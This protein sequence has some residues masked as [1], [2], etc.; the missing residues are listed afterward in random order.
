MDDARW[1]H[2]DEQGLDRLLPGDP[3]ALDPA[4]HFLEGDQEA[5]A[6]YVLSLDAVNFGSGWFHGLERRPGG[7]GY[8]VVARRLADRFRGEGGWAPED[9]SG[10]LPAEAADVFGLPAGHE[11]AGLFAQALR[12]LGDFL[13]DR[14][15]MDVV[16]AAGGSAEALATDLAGGMPMWRDVGF[17]KRAQIAASDLVLAGVARFDDLDRLTIFADNLVPHVLRVD[18]ALHVEPTLAAHLDAGRLLPPG[19]RERELRASAVVAGERLAHRF[20]V[21]ERELDG[22]L[23]QRGQDRRYEKPP[24]HRCH[25]FFY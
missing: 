5:V 18:G 1:V 3:P 6:M 22:M 2:I 14:G 10:L 16:A 25:T 7:F 24:P 23:W 19:R 11:L 21:T 15:A 4:S 12:E 9:L 20:R 13:T 8:P 17:Y